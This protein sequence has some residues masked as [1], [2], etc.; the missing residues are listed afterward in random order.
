MTNFLT[1]LAERALGVASVVQPLIVSRFAPGPALVGEAPPGLEQEEAVESAGEGTQALFEREILKD[2]SPPASPPP[3]LVSEG[4]P[5]S[6]MPNPPQRETPDTGLPSGRR[7]E[8][9]VRELGGTSLS[10]TPTPHRAVPDT[11]SPPDHHVKPDAGE[12]DQGPALPA[13]QDV[14]SVTTPTVSQRPTPETRSASSRRAESGPMEQAEARP[15]QRRIGP[16]APETFVPIPRLV[17]SED[18]PAGER[19]TGSFPTAL[20]PPVE[21][22]DGP[23][24]PPEPS[25]E[26]SKEVSE[27]QRASR[28]SR[29]ERRQVPE[30]PPSTTSPQ[31]PL[32][33]RVLRPNIAARRE[34]ARPMPEE[35][36]GAL[37]ELPSSPPTVRV[38]IGR[39]EVR[40]ILPPTSPPPRI[41]PARRGPALSLDDYLKQRNEGQR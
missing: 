40:A 13:F 11:E 3:I 4:A 23:S 32:V 5:P 37:P 26:T 16:Q 18:S 20:E 41:P 15:S 10:V 36:E 29:P 8:P 39:V 19:S 34:P 17:R 14:P 7:I 35:Q 9:N 2:V 21:E 28:P 22:D 25:P 6:V 27:S 38:T 31:R 24:L 1:R 33:P 30:A 12:E